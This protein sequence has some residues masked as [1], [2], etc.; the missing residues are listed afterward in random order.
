MFL[1]DLDLVITLVSISRGVLNWLY[2]FAMIEV[3]ICWRIGGAMF[4]FASSMS[5]ANDGTAALGDDPRA[6]ATVVEVEDTTEAALGEWAPRL[7]VVVL[8]S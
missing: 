2:L 3:F 4:A 5:G 8:V 7:W 6:E 1:R